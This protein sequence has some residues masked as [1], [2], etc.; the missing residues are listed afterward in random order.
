[1]R[2][3]YAKDLKREEEELR[4]FAELKNAKEEKTGENNERR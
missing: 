2:K 1:M 4:Y 3:F